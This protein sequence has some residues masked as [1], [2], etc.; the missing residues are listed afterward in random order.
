MPALNDA[1]NKVRAR[2]HTSRAVTRARV[3][4]VA[5]RRRGTRDGWMRA[6]PTAPFPRRRDAADARDDDDD[7]ARWCAN[8]ID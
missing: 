3:V 5:R 2:E 7:D 6:R 1:T 4:T 8:A